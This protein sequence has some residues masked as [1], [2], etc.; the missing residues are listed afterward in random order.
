VEADGEQRAAALA[1]YL[2]LLLL[3]VIIMLV[4][5]GSLLV[6]RDVATRAVV[7]LVD[8]YTPLTA[9]QERAAEAAIRGM[10]AVRGAISLTAFVLLL[11]GALQFLRSLIWTT[12]RI[13]HLRPHNWWRLP[14]Q[15]LGLLGI[16]ASAAVVGILLPGV[17]RLIQRWLTTRLALPEWAF[18]LVFSL[19]P[20]LVLF[21]GL[22]MIYKLAPSRVT[23]FAEVWL[24]GLAA[25]VVI[26]IGELV[27]L[28]YAVNVARFNVLYGALGGAMAVLLWIYLSSCVGVFGV[29]VC[30]AQAE[31][32]QSDRQRRRPGE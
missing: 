28:S 32:R 9:E 18:A 6:E 3:P 26:W 16:A 30:A 7:Q 8:R 11:V 20:W 5:A 25:T 12:N 4:N 29:C 21:C 31:A 23:G 24:G 14:L 22:S 10:L 2:L 13:W 1:Y 19:I 17:A 15:S 27:F